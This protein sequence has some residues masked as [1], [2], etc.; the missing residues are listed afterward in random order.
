[1]RLTLLAALLTAAP[2]VSASSPAPLEITEQRNAAVGFALTASA[3]IER[4]G[5]SCAAVPE[6]STQFSEA[7]RKWASRNKPYADAARAWMSYVK[8]VLAAEKGADVA[9]A[10]VSNTYSVFSDQASLMAAES[11]P[12]SPPTVAD[13]LKWAGILN[14]RKFDFDQN[15][16]FSRDLRDIR[17]SYEHEATGR[18]R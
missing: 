4:M 17:E 16:E 13:C 10:F 5:N 1:M 18:M 12:G 2:M 15:A 7:S 3:A 14:A 6:A 11:L 8:S 9:D